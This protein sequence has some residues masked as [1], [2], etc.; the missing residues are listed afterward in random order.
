MAQFL[1]TDEINLQLSSI[2]EKA[3]KKATLISPYL[4]FNERLR[5]LIKSK[6]DSGAEVI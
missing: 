4:S 6:L 5:Q 3:D 1:K 2:I